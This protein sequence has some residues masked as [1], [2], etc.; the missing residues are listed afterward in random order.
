M[1]TGYYIQNGYIYGPRRSGV[2]SRRR[3][4][5]RHRRPGRRA[6]LQLLRQHHD[7]EWELLPVH[8]LR[9]HERVL[10]VV[11]LKGYRFSDAIT[12]GQTSTASAAEGNK[13]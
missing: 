4:A 8:E 13:S 12:G 10:V 1:Y 5:G 7:A 6:D 2:D 3:C 9:E 11:D